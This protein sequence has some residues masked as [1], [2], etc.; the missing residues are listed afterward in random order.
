LDKTGTGLDKEVDKTSRSS[1]KTFGHVSENKRLTAKERWLKEHKEVRLYL[2]HD[3][4]ELLESLASEEGLTVRDYILELARG[5][6]R[7]EAEIYTLRELGVNCK[8]TGVAECITELKKILL[9]QSVEA[10]LEYLE[11]LKRRL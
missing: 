7:F 10:C 4:Y 2:R 8:P 1:G 9:Q 6:K 3:E 11:W 5:L